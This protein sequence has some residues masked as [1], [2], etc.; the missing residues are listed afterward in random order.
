M[1]LA[2]FF[3]PLGT[4]LNNPQHICLLRLSA[5]GDVCHA[6]A[7]IERIQRHW[8]QIQ[9]TWIIGKIEYQLVKG[10][11][12]VEFIIFD[13]RGG[14]SAV[15]QLK[16]QL[17]KRC[18]DALLIMQVAL[19]ANW[20]SRHI[21]AKRRIGFDWNRSK[22]LHWL[23]TN[24]RIQKKPHQHVFDGFM[25]FA[26]ALG[27]P[28]ISDPSWPIP[29]SAEEA[30]LANQLKQELGRYIIVSPA[31]SNPDRNWLAERYAAVINHIHEKGIS[32]VLCGSPASIEQQLGA[33]IIKHGANISRN[34]IG[35]TSLKQLLAVIAQAELIIAPDTGPAHMA[36]CVDTPVIGLYAHSNPRR[37]G[38]YLSQAHTVSVYDETIAQQRNKT[39][40]QLPW[41]T[42]AKG[43]D[44]MQKIEIN[45]VLKA[46]DSLLTHL[47]LNDE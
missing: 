38:P 23:F 46:V 13:K 11:P 14:K 12:G 2:Q 30:A 41:G 47:P 36:T 16:Q 18:F 3:S 28:A 45:D 25:D 33:S 29:I 21:H 44:L 17:G 8:P 40:Q 27:V 39:W 9:I 15:N 35:Q 20:L 19:R 4:S 43:S 6:V 37:T 42:R 34:L 31:A 5:I 26:D 1:K 24:E 22:E 7:M 10:M 32:V